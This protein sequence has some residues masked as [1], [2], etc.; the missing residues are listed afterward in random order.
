MEKIKIKNNLRRPV[1]FRVPGKSI[2]MSP[3]QV[4]EIPGYYKEARQVKK[5]CL[6]N[7]L[8]ILKVEEKTKAKELTKTGIEKKGVEIPKETEAEKLNA[9]GKKESKVEVKAKD[10]NKE[11]RPAKVPAASSKSR[12]KKS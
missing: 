8:T 4:A 9:E 11:K 3:G 2:R 1:I 7:S 5:L 10:E 6:R 12:R